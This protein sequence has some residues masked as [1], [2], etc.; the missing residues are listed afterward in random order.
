M[1]HVWHT[2]GTRAAHVRHTWNAWGLEEE[3]TTSTNC[4]T[5]ACSPAAG[6]ADAVKSPAGS[7]RCHP[8]CLTCFKHHCSTLAISSSISASEK[9]SG[10]LSG[11]LTCGLQSK[12]V[13]VDLSRRSN[14]AISLGGVPSSSCHILANRVSSSDKV[15]QT[16]WLLAMTTQRS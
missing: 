1:A 6:L 16:C 8:I 10:R 2:R 12:R 15:F 5:H 3:L 13:S 14:L 9:A 7:C 11:V 4:R